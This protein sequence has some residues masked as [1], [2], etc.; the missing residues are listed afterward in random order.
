MP[1]SC[2]CQRLSRWVVQHSFGWLTRYPR[3]V[4]DYE[5][6]LDVSVAMICLA[7]GGLLVRL[8]FHP[9]HSQTDTNK[10]YS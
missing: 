1:Y 9:R 7:I 6:R 10:L 2:S 4:R 8:I 5:R 3:L